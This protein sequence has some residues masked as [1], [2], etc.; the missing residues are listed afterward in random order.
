MIVRFDDAA[1]KELQE[2]SSYY[3]RERPGLGDEFIDAVA[4]A[5]RTIAEA[6]R[7][8]AYVLRPARRYR[9]DRFPYGIVYRIRRR[10]VEVLA[11][12]HLSRNPDYWVGRMSNH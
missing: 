7:R 8:W 5:T 2:A 9:L 10:E 11:V 12:M 1:T 4:A 6:P 3:D